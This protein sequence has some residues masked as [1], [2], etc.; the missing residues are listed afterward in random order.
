MPESET[1]TVPEVDIGRTRGRLARLL[2]R[3]ATASA[4]TPVAVAAFELVT[5]LWKDDAWL[6]IWRRVLVAGPGA[7]IGLMVLA[8]L[9]Y[10]LTATQRR[11]GTVA[12]TGDRID[13]RTADG[14]A[15][16]QA[17]RVTGAVVVPS[18]TSARAELTL[19][20]GDTLHAS[21]PTIRAAEAWLERLGVDPSRRAV[22][23]PGLGPAKT[24]LLALGTAFAAC[25]GSLVAFGMAIS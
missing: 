19:A 22:S 25:F 6:S 8:A 4:L 10:G 2:R 5:N 3:I 9:V 14:R 11:R 13:A 18:S 17:E 23:I 1:E 15:L 7:G 21:F 12:L 24:T 16:A 20:G